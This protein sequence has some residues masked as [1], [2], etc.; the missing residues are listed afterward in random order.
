[1]SKMSKVIFDM[2]RIDDGPAPSSRLKTI[3]ELLNCVNHFLLEEGNNPARHC[4]S[5]PQA[6]LEN[7]MLVYLSGFTK[8]LGD[9]CP[10]FSYAR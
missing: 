2:S 5:N 9:E 3:E 7:E 6:Q 8:Q 1:M 10:A 4:S